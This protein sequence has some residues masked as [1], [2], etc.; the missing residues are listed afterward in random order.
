M[1]TINEFLANSDT[2]CDFKFAN[3][4]V[5]MV[6]TNADGEKAFFIDYLVK[7]G[8]SIETTRIAGTSKFHI[9]IPASTLYAHA[10]LC[11]EVDVPKV[12]HEI[13]RVVSRVKNLAN[14]W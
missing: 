3:G 12:V 4:D 13:L 6:L 2:L 1:Q 5:Y 9:R 7:T 8:D 11:E 10:I 14:Y